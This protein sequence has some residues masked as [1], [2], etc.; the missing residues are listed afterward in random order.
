MDTVYVL[1]IYEEL[2]EEP[3][4]WAIHKTQAGAEKILQLT[5][6]DGFVL[7]ISLKD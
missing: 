2:G 3:K 4:V 7:P 1:W 6:K 5:D